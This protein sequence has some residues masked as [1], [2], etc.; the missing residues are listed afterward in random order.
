MDQRSKIAVVLQAG[1]ISDIV[2]DTP[3][4]FSDIDFIVIDYD[5]EGV[6]EE[7]LTDIPQSDEE[8]SKAIISIHKV[9]KAKINLNFMSPKN[10]EASE[11]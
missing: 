4:L 10:H 6:E 2:S 3:E 5:C 9:E 1:F 8:T 11:G 7:A